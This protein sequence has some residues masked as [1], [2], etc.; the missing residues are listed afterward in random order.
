VSK[1]V[2]IKDALTRIKELDEL[3]L[4]S[5]T[6][7]QLP[8]VTIAYEE[9]M[10]RYQ[11][12]LH[13]IALRYLSNN[14]DA[15][16]VVHEVMLK[17]FVHI[18]KFENRASFKTWIY[19]LTYNESVDKIR[20]IAKH[21]TVQDQEIDFLPAEETEHGNS[22]EFNTIDSWMKTLNA[23]DRSIVVFRVQFELDFKEIAEIVG[24]NLSTVKMK[25]RRSLEKLR[26]L[27]VQCNFT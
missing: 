19:R 25:H 10:R 8:Y 6:Q 24:L 4:V 22:S 11:K 3:E 13:S 16:E 5:L 7:K 17:V 20:A 26:R 15:E 18:K 27:N 1:H 2:S 21:A 14:A 23:I 12:H 9:L